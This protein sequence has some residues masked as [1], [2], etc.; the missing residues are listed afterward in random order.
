MSRFLFH[1]LIVA[2]ALAL[3][4]YLLPGVTIAS[5]LSLAIAALVLGFI[6]AVV[7]P[8]LI[9]LTLP[10]TILTLGLFLLVVNGLAFALAAALVPGFSVAGIGWGILGAL[11]VSVVSWILG[12]ALPDKR[13]G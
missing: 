11:L 7:R 10:I 4:A 8:L 5:P 3:T 1:W 6:N 13:K 2:V 9:L 12:A